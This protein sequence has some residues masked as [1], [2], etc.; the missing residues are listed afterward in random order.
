MGAAAL[1]GP[2]GIA[3]QLYVFDFWVMFVA[4]LALIIFIGRRQPI[5]RK[6]GAAL[7][8]GYLLYLA[9]LVRAVI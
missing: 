8:I 4:M 3:K 5:G 9:A 1:S 7:F 6:T 2:V